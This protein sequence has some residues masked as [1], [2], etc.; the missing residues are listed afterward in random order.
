MTDAATLQGQLDA[1]RTAY[2][3]G[4]DSVSYDGKSVR[5]RSAEEMRAAIASLENQINGLTGAT[6]PRSILIRSSKGW[7]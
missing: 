7:G 3:T 1:L 2:A 6:P 4:T 5:Y